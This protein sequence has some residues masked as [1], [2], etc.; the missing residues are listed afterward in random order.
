L[1]IDYGH[2]PSAIG[3]T[4]QAL[5]RHAYADPFVAPGDVDVT[6]HV[7]FAALMRAAASAGA[8]AFG[9]LTQAELLHRLGIAARADRL[10]ATASRDA[11]GRIDAALARLTNAGRTGMGALFKAVA[12]AHPAFGAPPA[13]AP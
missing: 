5:G 7:D 12:L 10:K 11:A 9:P 6:A 13:F 8:A 2:A 4:L 1:V 3:D